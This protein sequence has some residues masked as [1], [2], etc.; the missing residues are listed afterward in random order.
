MLAVALMESGSGDAQLDREIDEARKSMALVNSLPDV[1]NDPAI[2]R[3]AATLYLKKGDQ[4]RLGDPAS[5]T[6][7]Y[8]DALAAMQR[9]IA[10]LHAIAPSVP[11]NA[12]SGRLLSLVYERLGDR[13]RAITAASQARQSD[14]LNP[15]TYRQ[16]ADAD[17]AAGRANDAAIVLMEGMIVTQDLAIRRELV[18][19]YQSGIDT[20]GCALIDGPNGKAI[21]PACTLIHN[22]LC[23]IAPDAIQVRLATGRR[24]IAEQM[25]HSFLSDYGCPAGPIDAAMAGSSVR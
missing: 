23:A 7:V 20:Q 4:L 21:N 19:V 1:R 8:R 6:Q 11:L 15:L 13:D 14:P 25:R 18:D 16:L 3:L 22:H 10:I 12:E 5:A 24:D 17:L 2:Y 9:N